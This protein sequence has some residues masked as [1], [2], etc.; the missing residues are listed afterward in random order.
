MYINVSL[1]LIV[2]KL[3][4]ILMSPPVN[5]D[6]PLKRNFYLS[7]ASGFAGGGSGGRK[8]KISLAVAFFADN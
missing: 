7:R 1:W 3:F 6:D 8:I 4:V 2:N 5:S